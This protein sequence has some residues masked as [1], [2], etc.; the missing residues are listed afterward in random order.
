MSWNNKF[1]YTVLLF[2]IILLGLLNIKL[3]THNILAAQDEYWVYYWWLNFISNWSH[4]IENT[5][6]K[7]YNIGYP[8]Y[9]SYKTP[10]TVV[11]GWFPYSW[12]TYSIYY[13]F[14]IEYNYLLIFCM[15]IVFYIWIF[16]ILNKSFLKQYQSVL[17]SLAISTFPLFIFYF[18]SFFNNNITLFLVV[19]ISYLLGKYLDHKSGKFLYLLL[20]FS[21]VLMITRLPI[22]L[23]N[24]LILFIILN[25]LKN[26]IITIIFWIFWLIMI[27]II[28]FKAYWSFTYMPY[29]NPFPYSSMLN[30]ELEWT[31][32]KRNFIISWLSYLLWSDYGLRWFNFLSLIQNVFYHIKI[33]FFNSFLSNI[34]LVLSGLWILNIVARR[35]IL[36]YSS[37]SMLYHILLLSFCLIYFFWNKWSYF[38]YWEVRLNVNFFRYIMIIYIPIIIIWVIFLSKYNKIAFLIIWISIV[39]TNI[40]LWLN[41][42]LIYNNYK[43]STSMISS[44]IDKNYNK[45]NYRFITWYFTWKYL[46]TIKKGLTEGQLTNISLTTYWGTDNTSH[47][48]E[49]KDQLINLVNENKY[50]YIFVTVKKDNVKRN[51]EERNLIF[52]NFKYTLVNEVDWVEF[53]LISTYEDNPDIRYN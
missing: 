29:L 35:I 10:S 32:E 46:Y 19:I 25:W 5:L 24:F 45:D 38:G 21:V 28:N 27:G 37:K 52:D 3:S 31:Y 50:K 17:I 40:N 12:I 7:E 48:Q 4:I 47:K 22:W 16:N 13:L 2:A 6:W 9:V 14:F 43:K 15:Q 26:K 53:F 11:W 49:I 34:V 33:T 20:F 44:Y 51:D 18:T 42:I 30:S 36:K 8:D 1:L 39:F 23:F 41:T